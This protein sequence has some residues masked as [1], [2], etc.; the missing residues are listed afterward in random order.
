MPGNQP[1]RPSKHFPF[2]LVL[3]RHSDWSLFLFLALLK[4]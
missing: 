1:F 3:E 4:F 2:L